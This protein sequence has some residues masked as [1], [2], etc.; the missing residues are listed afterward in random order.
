MEG[1]LVPPPFY[2]PGRDPRDDA[3]AGFFQ[4]AERVAA[5]CRVRCKRKVTIRH[6]YTLPHRQ[7]GT[8]YD[9]TT[10]VAHMAGQGIAD[11]PGAS[12]VRNVP[13]IAAP[14]VAWFSALGGTED[15]VNG[16]IHFPVSMPPG[17]EP[18]ASFTIRRQKL[19]A[20]VFLLVAA[21]VAWE[22]MAAAR[23]QEGDASLPQPQSLPLP[24]DA[25]VD[26]LANV[27]M[28]PTLPIDSKQ[29]TPR[30]ISVAQTIELLHAWIQAY[31]FGRM[32][33]VEVLRYYMRAGYVITITR[34]CGGPHIQ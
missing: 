18:M 14:P 29:Y 33:A 7:N 27:L 32:S 2:H 20:H 6:Q 5:S 25:T 13:P 26:Y 30:K 16:T 31:I 11:S 34:K 24:C 19:P 23:Q 1:S 12:V 17:F 28:D 21:D 22:R 8:I 15:Y 3:L 10:Y 4:A 9:K